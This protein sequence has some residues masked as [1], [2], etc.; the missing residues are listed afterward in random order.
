[1]LDNKGF[2]KWAGEYDASIKR[3]SEGYPFEGYYNVLSYVYS[4]IKES[5][6]TKILDVGV[7]TGLLTHEL[8]KNGKKIDRVRINCL[9]YSSF[10]MCRSFGN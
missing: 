9:I 4:L 2:D 1:M 10:I 8:Y 3:H 7:G 6:E 5:K